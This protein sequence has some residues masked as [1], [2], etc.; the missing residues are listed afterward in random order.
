MKE[1]KFKRFDI[2]VEK[3]KLPNKTTALMSYMIHNGGV[4]ILAIYEKKIA[5]IKQYRPSIKKYIFE[6]PAGTLEKNEDPKIRAKK[7]LKEET[8]LITDKVKFLFKSY[9]TP[10]VSNEMHYFFLAFPNKKQKQE[11]EKHEVIKLEFISFEQI[12]QMIKNNK[13][14]SGPA[15][16]ALLFYL[17]NK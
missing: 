6:L 10:G 15:I 11:L 16:Q 2:K 8:G 17:N 9:P 4:I 12:K 1:Y 5:M 13:I 7:E 14:M 3:V